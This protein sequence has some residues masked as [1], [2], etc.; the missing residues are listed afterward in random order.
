MLAATSLSFVTSL[1]ASLASFSG[2]FFRHRD[3]DLEKK[4]ERKKRKRKG[5]GGEKKKKWRLSVR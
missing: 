1:L 5:K 3:L 2:I 4:E